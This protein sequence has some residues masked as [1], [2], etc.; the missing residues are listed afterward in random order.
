MFGRSD[1]DDYDRWIEARCDAMHMHSCPSSPNPWSRSSSPG[2]WS[3]SSYYD[4]SDEESDFYLWS[5]ITE[6][7]AIV[8][9]ELDEF[10]K[11]NLDDVD[12]SQDFFYKNEEFLNIIWDLDEFFESNLDS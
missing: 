9:W 7:Y 4:D 11:S 1:F 12:E 3:D 10:F 8:H 2:L 5:K 6:D